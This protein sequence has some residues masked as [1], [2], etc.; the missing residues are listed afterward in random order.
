MFGKEGDIN[1]ALQDINGNNIGYYSIRS[2]RKG[3]VYG[4]FQ[5]MHGEQISLSADEKILNGICPDC[6]FNKLYEGVGT[7][8]E[9]FIACSVCGFFTQ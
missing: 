8:E 6:N 1:M 7:D 5:G 2:N 3:G 9:P 4:H